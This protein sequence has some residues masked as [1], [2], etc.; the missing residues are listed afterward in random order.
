MKMQKNLPLLLLMVVLLTSVAAAQEKL[1][2][3]ETPGPAIVYQ[4][5][6]PITI[7]GNEYALLT[8][9]MDFPSGAGVPSHFHGGYVSVTVLSGEM[10]LR[11]N[12][13]EKVLKTGESWTE[14]PGD[15]HEVVNKGASARVAVSMLLPK[16]AE[17]TTP[18]K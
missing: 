8:M 16:G 3:S 4:S 11:H 10:T 13:T 12:D 6:F 9:I 17:V 1:G 2:N 14:N 5:K 7:E 15:I 18:V